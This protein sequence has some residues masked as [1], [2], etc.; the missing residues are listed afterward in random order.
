MRLLEESIAHFDSAGFSWTLDAH[1]L[2]TSLIFN[3]IATF[4]MN[5]A[6]LIMTPIW[7]QKEKKKKKKSDNKAVSGERGQAITIICCVSA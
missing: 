5:G 1:L 6:P 7:V 4:S 3:H 2:M